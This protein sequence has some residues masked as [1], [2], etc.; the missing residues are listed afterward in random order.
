[1][2]VDHQSCVV[3]SS[4]D[5]ISKPHCVHDQL[6]TTASD[7]ALACSKMINTDVQSVCEGAQ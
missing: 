4:V 5:A 7:A 3:I 6:L 2:G 1:V